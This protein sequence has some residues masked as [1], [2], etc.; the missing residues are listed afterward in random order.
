MTTKYLVALAIYRDTS[1]DI[2]EHYK[3]W[4]V[5]SVVVEFKEPITPENLQKLEDTAVKK[6]GGT[7]RYNLISFSTFSNP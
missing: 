4:K 5:S 1:N 2:D 6:L 7:Y 3:F